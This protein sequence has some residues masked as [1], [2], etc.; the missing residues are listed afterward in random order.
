MSKKKLIEQAKEL[1]K[2]AKENPEQFQELAKVRIQQPGGKEGH[3]N[4]GTM[5][6]TSNAIKDF[7]GKDSSNSIPTAQQ[8]A[9]NELWRE[10]TAPKPNLPKMEKEE[11]G[12]HKPHFGAAKRGTGTSEVGAFMAPGGA[13]SKTNAWA[14]DKH[15]EKLGELKNM[16]KP[17][18]P[19]SEMDKAEHQ[20]HPGP[21]R[22]EHQKAYDAKQQSESE[23]KLKTPEGEAAR[24]A[25]NAKLK[26]DDMAHAPNSPQDKAHD[27][28]EHADTMNHAM[29]ILDTPEKQKAMLDHLRTLHE[30]AQLRSPENA[31]AGQAPQEHKENPMDKAEI[32]K[33]AKELIELAKSEPAKFEEMTKAMAAPAPAPAMAKPAAPKMQAPRPAMQAKPAGAARMTK[34]EIKA[35]C[36]AP[37]EPKYRKAK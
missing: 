22:S 6:R 27:V 24:Q 10:K 11:K 23:A 7:H 28:A 21:S 15:K 33:A 32:I 3:S 8:E 12:V 19:K 29:K 17:N 4:I 37:W 18:L 26:K 20:P 34:E 2:A 25:H 14:K 1:L 35:D 31:E 16:P 9:R 36:A 30:P 13:S 5:V